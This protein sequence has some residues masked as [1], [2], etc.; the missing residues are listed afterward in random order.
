ML[1]GTVAQAKERRR[2]VDAHRTRPKVGCCRQRH[3]AIPTPEVDKE[4]IARDAQCAQSHVDAAVRSLHKWDPALAL[5]VAEGGSL[6][7]AI[8]GG[9]L[10]GHTLHSELRA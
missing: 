2:D 1:G 7:F 9:F 6:I 3:P 10:G 8:L 5:G 4:I